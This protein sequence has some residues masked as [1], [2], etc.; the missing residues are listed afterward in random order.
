MP[1]PIPKGR[2]F[3]I[4][5]VESN[6]R[7]YMPTMSSASHYETAFIISGDRQCLTPDCIFYMHSGCVT[8]STPDLPRQT[9]STMDTPYKRILVKFSADVADELRNYFGTRVL[10]ELFSAHVHYFD[11]KHKIKIEQLFWEMYEEYETYCSYT[12][13]LLRGMIFRLFTMII[14]YRTLQEDL[15]TFSLND[16]HPL[17]FKAISFM[18]IH[19]NESPNMEAISKHV[20]LSPAYFSKLFKKEMNTTYSDYLLLIRL[21]KSRVLLMQTTLS[22][23]DIADHVGL[24]NGNYLSTLFK[25]YYHETPLQFRKRLSTHS[26]N[27][28]INSP[29]YE[30]E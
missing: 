8:L 11:E 17:I 1:Y 27:D 15:L 26:T 23:S 22:I 2:N 28:I 6:S 19:C 7:H 3:E 5:Y 12:D 18:S 14:R 10:E 25:K 13:K 30:S 16:I 21:Q 4:T 29:L 24:C 9:S 20:G